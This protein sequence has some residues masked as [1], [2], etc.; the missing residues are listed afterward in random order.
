VVLK[1]K[2]LPILLLGK[3]LQLFLGSLKIVGLVL[4]EKMD[5]SSGTAP[6]CRVGDKREWPDYVLPLVS[7]ASEGPTSSYTL[8]E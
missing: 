2:F 5:K 3:H 1:S 8:G 7:C 4:M 6:G